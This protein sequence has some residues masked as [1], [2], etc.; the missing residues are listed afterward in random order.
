MTISITQDIRSITDLKQHA[1]DILRQI[2]ITKRPVV[3]TVSGK[4]RV[5][6]VDAGE[7]EK[8]TAALELAR[9]LLPAED[10]IRADRT[11][12]AGEFFQEFKRVQKI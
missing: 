11:R 5:V 8:T 1:N 4:A 7:Y 2:Q 12:L 9:E 10:D 6:L 3:L